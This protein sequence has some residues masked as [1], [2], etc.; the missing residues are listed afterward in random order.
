[1]LGWDGV[2][3]FFNLSHFDCLKAVKKY[4]CISNLNSASPNIFMV[5]ISVR[6]Q[7]RIFSCTYKLCVLLLKK[8]K[9]LEFSHLLLYITDEGNLGEGQKKCFTQDELILIYV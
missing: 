8:L 5:Y 2:T 1:M 7:I 3:T 4:T 9:S 6:C